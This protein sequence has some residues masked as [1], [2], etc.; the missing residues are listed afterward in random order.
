MVSFDFLSKPI[1]FLNN[2]ISVLYIEN[3]SLYRK[4]VSALYGS[5]PEESNIIF[6]QNFNPINFKNNVCFVPN[7]FTVDFSTPFVKK[8][9][10]D[11]ADYSNT[12]LFEDLAFLNSN[13][14]FFLEKLSF[15]F[16]YDFDYNSQFDI[17]DLLKI[18]SFKPSLNQDDL[19]SSLLDYIILTNKYTSPKCFVI[20]NLHS[21]FSSSELEILYKELMYQNIK[22]LVIEGKKCFDTVPFEQI[23]I[24]DEDMCEIVDK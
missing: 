23:Y 8:V 2:K 22:L 6:S 24:V 13:I 7:V 17:T 9:Y 20:L 5:S 16:D 21:C 18:Q 10:A 3:Q 12:Y 4:T 19:L 11:L 1:E 15:S 14:M